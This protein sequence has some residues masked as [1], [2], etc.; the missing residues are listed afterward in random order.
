MFAIIRTRPYFGPAPLGP[1]GKKLL[2]NWVY[3]AQP[4][5][6]DWAPPATPHGEH[7]VIPPDLGAFRVPAER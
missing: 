2:T 1:A 6:Y 3:R 4:L 7:A 5:P